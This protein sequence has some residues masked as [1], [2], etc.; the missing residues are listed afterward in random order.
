MLRGHP[1]IFMPD[2]K[3]PN[4]FADELID[5]KPPADLPATIDDYLSLFAPARPAQLAGEASV[6]YLWSRTSARNIAQ[7]CPDA[8]IIT[9]VRE[10][11]SF[12][13]SLHLQLLNTRVESQ[14]DLSTALAL[15]DT[16]REGRH[17][18]ET[19]YWPQLLYYSDHMTYMA[20]L[21]R[22]SDAFPEHQRLT[23]IYDDF[24]NDNRATLEKVMRFLEIDDTVSLSI[25]DVN[26]STRMRAKHVKRLLDAAS[27]GR[28][29]G[30]S[31]FKRAAE[32]VTTQNVRHAAKRAVQRRVIEGKPH[33]PDAALMKRLRLRYKPEVEALADHLGRD[34]IKLWGYDAL[35]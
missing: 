9:I 8:R 17:L 19:G 26:Q 11:A 6:L 1:Q 32:A 27:E 14:P 33:K 28:G 18:S 24:R 34:L 10:P 13:C 15:E 16:R 22:Y 25:E 20:Q 31:L 21:T 7:A 30:F 2:L 23:L 12:L 3:E 5:N 4:Y 29:A 35:T